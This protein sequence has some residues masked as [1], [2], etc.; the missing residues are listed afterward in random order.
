MKYNI[1]FSQRV[2]PQP[3]VPAPYGVRSSGHYRLWKNFHQ[4]ARENLNFLELFWVESGVFVIRHEHGNLTLHAHEACF[5]FPGDSHEYWATEETDLCWLTI[6]GKHCSRLVE[7]YDLTRKPFFAGRCP[8]EKFAQ[9]RIEID[10]ISASGEYSALASA[11]S[12][13]LLALSS[14]Y[15]KAELPN[16]ATR[17]KKLAKQHFRD[18]DCGVDILAEKLNVHRATLHRVVSDSIRIS[19]AEFIANLRLREAISLLRQGCPIA[20]TAELSGYA[21][22]NYMSKVIRRKTGYSPGEYRRQAPSKLYSF[23]P[24]VSADTGYDLPDDEI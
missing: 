2:F 8:V 1:G 14:N 19:P 20:R 4:T 24:A 22:A 3:T 15:N 13:I 11:L 6:D 17:F 10:E 23:P 12:I 5:L 21:N 16:L 9:L 18:K 7:D